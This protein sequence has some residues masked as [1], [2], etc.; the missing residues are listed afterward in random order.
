MMNPSISALPVGTLCVTSDWLS[1]ADSVTTTADTFYPA[2]TAP[3]A[4]NFTYWPS[5][6]FSAAKIE[7][8]LSEVMYLRELAVDDK[9]L[10]KV[11]KKFAP[12]IEITVDFPG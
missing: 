5:Y 12:Y 10:R 9:K 3:T 4:D 7:L 11:L 6:N 2:W 1:S 8:K